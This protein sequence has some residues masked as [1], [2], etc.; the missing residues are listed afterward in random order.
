M[1]RSR[2]WSRTLDM[3]SISECVNANM[4]SG[5]SVGHCFKLKYF[6][7][8]ETAFELEIKAFD[9]DP[10]CLSELISSEFTKA[11]M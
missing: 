7:A 2:I 6:T 5:L 3:F 1:E 11:P 9:F 4:P 10:C 8:G